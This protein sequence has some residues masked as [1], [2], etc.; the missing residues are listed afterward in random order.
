MLMSVRI[1]VNSVVPPPVE[2]NCPAN[3]VEGISAV[4]A[5]EFGGCGAGAPVVGISP[6]KTVPESTHARTSADA[7]CLILSLFSFELRDAS[8]LARKQHSVNTYSTI[9]TVSRAGD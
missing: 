7:K 2:G 9:D 4:L 3:P 1:I 8:Q 5:I 6:A